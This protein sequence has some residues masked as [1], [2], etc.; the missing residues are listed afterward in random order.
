MSKQDQF[1]SSSLTWLL[2]DDPPGVKYL[3]LRDLLE[4]PKGNVQL[5]AAYKA[6]HH[7]GPIAQI[8]AQ[9]DESGYWVKPGPGYT[10]RYRST[11]W[12]ILNLAQ[13]GARVEEDQRIAQACEYLLNNN[14]REG[15]QFTF[16]GAP[17]G[18]VDCLQGNLA[19]AL[20]E[21]GCEDQRLDR[22]FKW[23]ARS[24]TG[25]G[26]AP[27]E[28]QHASV[29]Y[30]AGKCGP[31]FACGY[32][33]KLPCAWGCVK[34][35][36]ALEKWPEDQR[37]PLFKRAIQ[38]GIDFLFSIDPALATYPTRHGEKPSQNWWKFGFP[39]FYITDLL[40]LVEVL[41]RLGYGADPRL[42]HAIAIIHEK[43]DEKRRWVL[44]HDHAG[45]TWASFGTLKMPNKWVTLRALRTL[46]AAIA[47]LY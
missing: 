40:Q 8:L 6:A 32:N 16:S 44:E 36:L 39:V 21:L 46:K 17:S 47:S 30:Y 5:R 45:K 11:V 25:E 7:E 3:A 33:N 35:L 12:S 1:D 13:L 14:L 38:R 26:I 27:V 20:L 19:W 28:D 42:A 23:M 10:Q 37:T 15:G 24:V 43:Q 34:V 9:M 22:A 31:D 41:A 4:Y 18:T 29:R 2:E